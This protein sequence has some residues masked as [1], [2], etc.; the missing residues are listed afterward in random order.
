MMTFDRW[1]VDYHGSPPGPEDNRTFDAAHKAFNYVFEQYAFE[2]ARERDLRRQS[3]AQCVRMRQ[4]WL[5]A[6]RRIAQIVE[7]T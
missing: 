1:W 2:L 6:K 3:E 5:D 7:R 4:R